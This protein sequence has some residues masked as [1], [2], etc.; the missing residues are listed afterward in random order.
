MREPRAQHGAPND[1][2]RTD[3]RF[4]PDVQA[5][6]AARGLVTRALRDRVGAEV[7]ERARLLASEL[8]TNSVRH[9]GAPADIE[10]VF[11]VEVSDTM[12]RLEVQDPGHDGAIAPRP[13]SECG[14]FGLNIV[15]TLSERW[16]LERVASGGTRV[17]AQI[18][19]E[20]LT[21]LSL[22]PAADG[23]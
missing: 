3:A 11:R 15:Q 14:G 13:P 17:W 8:T 9:S 21:A 10:L 12:V 2:E 22:P 1:V 19:L 23:V 4:L 7:L 16:G 18:A 5:P 6:T 20:P